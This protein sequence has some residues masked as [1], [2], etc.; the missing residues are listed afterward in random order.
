M[1][2]RH[3]RYALAVAEHQHFGRAA[4]ALGIAQ[5][6]LSQQIAALERELGARLFDRTARGVFPT[7]AGE[8]FLARARRALAEMSA[9]VSDAGRAARGETGRLR[10]GFIGSALLELLPSVLGQFIRDRPEVRLGLQEMST[11]RS[12]A[13][14]LA[15][16]LDIAIG[17][18][19]PRGAGAED[20][21]S[22]TVGRD[23]LVAVVGA[24]H[25]FAGQSKVSVEQLRGQHLIVAP[26]DEEPAV[27]AWLSALLGEGT[28]AS[29][30]AG[31]LTEAWDAHTI[32]GLASCGV[33]VGLGPTCLRV[34]A[35]PDVRVCEVS[36]RVELPEL[37]MSFRAQDRSP[38][39]AAFLDITRE[40]CPGVAERLERRLGTR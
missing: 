22:V 38:V 33:G 20:L 19:A 29:A 12:T 23:H 28:E 17:R 21:V 5:P 10:L 31:G 32:I 15:G 11:R 7:A 26:A 25:P 4:A 35:R 24:A 34:A 9:A 18:G 6:P 3:L 16:E 39:L 30:R 36:P 2:S 37:V 8:A 27:A 13:A 1:E 14:L 40:R